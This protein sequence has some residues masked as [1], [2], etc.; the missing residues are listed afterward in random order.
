MIPAAFRSGVVPGAV[1]IVDLNYEGAASVTNDA[2]RVIAGLVESGIDFAGRRVVYQDST[3]TWDEILVAGGKFAGFAPIGA[4]TREDA[5]AHV[6]V[7]MTIDL[8]PTWVGILP[9]LLAVIESGT[10]EGRRDAIKELRNMARAADQ[11]NEL[12]SMGAPP[13]GV[14]PEQD[15]ALRRIAA[16]INRE[17]GFDQGKGTKP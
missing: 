11:W 3:G 5:L 9:A 16:D 14:T 12:C 13:P 17:F 6:G 10:P 8:T 4:K 2:A 15:R 1:W 7:P